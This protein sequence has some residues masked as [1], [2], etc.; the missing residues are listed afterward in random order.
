MVFDTQKWGSLTIN[1][2]KTELFDLTMIFL[3]GDVHH[4]S[5]DDPDHD[6]ADITEVEAAVKYVKIAKKH[7]IK[8]TLFL[9][10]KCFIEEPDKVREVLKFDNVEIG[11][12][13]WNAF[14]FRPWH[15][16]SRLMLGSFYGPRF[17][18]HWDI[19]KTVNVI[20]DTSGKKC[21]SWRGHA[22]QGDSITEELLVKHEI[23]VFSNEVDTEARIRVLDNGLIS[24][25]INTLP[26]H[27]HIY[28]GHKT[29]KFVERDL[30][31][32]ENGPFSIFSLSPPRLK[33][34]WKRAFFELIK[35]IPRLNR[36]F[37]REFFSPQEWFDIIQEDIQNRLE[38]QGFKTILAHPLCMEIIDGM[39]SFNELCG[40]LSDVDSFFVS[41]LSES[42]I[43]KF[44]I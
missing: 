39:K 33:K 20:E 38:R 31:I 14:Q 35:K 34:E 17:Y 36:G 13:T 24:L 4:M 1:K 30:F 40:F 41:E 43:K 5:F 25:P 42:N 27:E 21:R 3:T 29:K 6:Y 18:Q 15:Y 44:N 11:G 16:I 19:E 28:H 37:S 2:I 12:H 7:G 9:T 10:G 32:R 22:F 23:K 8:V 26:D